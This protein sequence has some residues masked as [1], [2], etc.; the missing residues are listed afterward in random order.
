MKNV[1]SISFFFILLF[2]TN[3][4][5]ANCDF[6]TSNYIKELKSSNYI[7][8]ITI[9]TSKTK[10]FDKNF[11]RIITSEGSNIPPYLKKKKFK[12]IIK[13]K[14]DF[15]NC[16]YEAKL[17]QHGDWKNHVLLN[18]GRPLRSLDIKMIDGNIINAVKYKLLIP[19]TRFNKHEILGSLI[20]K[21]LGFIVPETFQVQTNINGDKYLMLF[22][23]KA[24]KELLERNNKRDL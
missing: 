17:R 12:A 2:K 6:N 15:G 10:K 8:L 1:L 9:T 16:T 18:N 19:E 20:L 23:E 22:Q 4:V 3:Y 5:F 13:V 14:Y 21:K 24:A 11:A 7:K